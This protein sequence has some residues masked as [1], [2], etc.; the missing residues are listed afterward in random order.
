MIGYVTVGVSDLSRAKEFYTEL[1]SSKGAQVQ[2]DA[3]RIVFIGSDPAAPM[4]AICEPY[5]GEACASGNGAMVAFA[6]ASKED[7]ST[8]YDKAIA[9]GATDE[10]EPGQRVPDRFYGA[11]ARDPDGNKLCFYVFG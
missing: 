7:V 4:L 8:L 9:L 11:Y 10:G 1:L 3:G 6:A 5:D 2:I